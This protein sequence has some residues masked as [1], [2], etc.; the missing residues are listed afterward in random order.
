MRALP[1]LLVFVLAPFDSGLPALAA[2]TPLGTSQDKQDVPESLRLPET[3]W[4]RRRAAIL[5]KFPDGAVAVDAGP[6]GEVG[7]DSNTPVFDF[8]YRT[9]FHDPEGVLVL[10]G[11]KSAVFVSEMRNVP[12]ID[13]ILKTDR[14]EAW[15]AEHLSKQPKIYT[16]L[17]QENLTILRNA[18]GSAEVVGARVAGEL[19]KLR[20]TKGEAELRLMRKAADANYVAH[21]AAM[22]AVRPGV[23][24]RAIHELVVSTFRNWPLA[25]AVNLAYPIA[26][27][28]ARD[29]RMTRA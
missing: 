15:A 21:L 2:S 7:S 20:L 19:S 6:L 18:A 3:E 24:E 4:A 26:S 12:G 11:E 23:N 1:A 28:S 5:G 16:K 14:F 8:K 10:A 27:S 17:R 22:K 9:G 13:T 25:M 29:G